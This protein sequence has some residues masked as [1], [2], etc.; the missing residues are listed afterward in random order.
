MIKPR[1]AAVAALPAPPPPLPEFFRVSTPVSLVF[2]A[3]YPAKGNHKD[4]FTL[5]RRARLTALRPRP[6]LVEITAAPACCCEA[7]LSPPSIRC[8]PPRRWPACQGV[9]AGAISSKS[10]NFCG[11]IGSTSVMVSHGSFRRSHHLFHPLNSRPKRVS[12]V[13]TAGE[14]SDRGLPRPFKQ[15]KLR[16]HLPKVQCPVIATP[17]LSLPASP[18]LSHLV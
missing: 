8:C 7:V 14:R 6:S 16:H 10:S 15:A 9:A 1:A 17:I 13:C 12:V 11:P 3:G 2:P 18:F 4:V 5:S